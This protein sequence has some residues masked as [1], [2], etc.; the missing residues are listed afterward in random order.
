MKRSIIQITIFSA[1]ILMLNPMKAFSQCGNTCGQPIGT[2]S[3]AFNNG[4]AR[5][6]YS[7]AVGERT[8]VN[9]DYGISMG[10]FAIIESTSTKSFNFGHNNTIH[11]NSPNSI[12]FGY[13][14]D[15]QSNASNAMLLG[16]NNNVLTGAANSILLGHDNRTDAQMTLALGK[17]NV[18]SGEYSAALGLGLRTEAAAHNS[19][20][21][22]FGTSTFEPY[23]L[24]F[25][26]GSSTPAIYVKG[27]D[28]PTDIGFVG[29]GNKE[30]HFKLDVAGNICVT[31]ENK[32]VFFNPTPQDGEVSW[33]VDYQLNK[34]LRFFEP[35]YGTTGGGS[36]GVGDDPTLNIVD[37]RVHLFIQ[38]QTGNVGIKAIRPL[39]DLQVNGKILINTPNSSLLFD[40]YGDPENPN[41]RWGIKY[42]SDGLNFWKPIRSLEAAPGEEELNYALFI[43]DTDG[44]IGIGTELPE[45]QLHVN[46]DVRI[47]DLENP[48]LTTLDRI[49]L[50]DADG[51]LKTSESL[52][53]NNNGSIG[54]G[55]DPN[56]DYTNFSNTWNNYKLYV[57]GG[58]MSSE[59][60][61]KITDNWS[62]FVFEENY[63]LRPLSE[64]EDFIKD[65]GHL[66][67]I[68][69]AEQV[70]EEGVNMGQMDAKLLQKIEE[71]TLYMIEQDKKI[72]ALSKELTEIKSN[73]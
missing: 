42:E 45:T 58:I 54:I 36:G 53:I 43:S 27:N 29:I 25:A 2:S 26:A 73:K 62:D 41:G 68:P 71:L 72:D 60:W 33:G 37:R 12:I 50:A 56:N 38:N 30:P 24:A 17:D 34:G 52:L 22:G 14:S 1:L 28:L 4:K 6:L 48:S 35:V 51:D 49:T 5:N 23:S 65:N 10:S 11:S 46:G 32:A 20:A 67:E 70:A 63:K 8:T 13:N 9:A 3:S 47:T 61:V 31:G 7:F 66:P 39:Q 15:I 55:L 57:N 19:I 44:K 18:L 69:S 40:N 16:Y 64:V 21:I 59:I